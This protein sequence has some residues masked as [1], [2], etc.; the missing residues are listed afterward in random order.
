MSERSERTEDTVEHLARAGAERQRGGG[1]SER[2][3]R[4]KDTVE[5]RSVMM[6]PSANE[7]L[8]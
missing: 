3:E 6:E 7:A 8:S 1:R 2:S 5:Y 4:S